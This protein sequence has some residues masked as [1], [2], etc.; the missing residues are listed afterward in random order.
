MKRGKANC[1]V[2]STHPKRPN[3]TAIDVS[4]RDLS[5]G[6][7]K[8]WYRCTKSGATQ[9]AHKFI[10][11]PFRVGQ[12][13]STVTL[14]SPNRP[15]VGPPRSHR[16]LTSNWGYTWG[17]AGLR[18]LGLLPDPREKAFNTSLQTLHLLLFR[19]TG[20]VVCAGPVSSCTSWLVRVDAVV[21]VRFQHVFQVLVV[22]VSRKTVL[23]ALRTHCLL[24]TSPSPRDRSLSRMPSSA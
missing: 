10:I 21:V 20:V 4:H 11:Y 18:K 12:W 14:C 8:S 13:S 19:H 6:A 24:Y 22:P 15:I 16:L 23:A 9:R 7:K 17:H 3:S 1:C 2:K 5:N